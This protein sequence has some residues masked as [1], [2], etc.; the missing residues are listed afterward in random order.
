MVGAVAD[1]Q[2]P[3]WIRWDPGRVDVQ[4]SRDEGVEKAT[5]DEDECPNTVERSA[6]VVQILIMIWCNYGP[7]RGGVEFVQSCQEMYG[8]A[9]PTKN[10]LLKHACVRRTALD[11][12]RFL[13][14]AFST[15]FVLQDSGL[16]F[17]SG[18]PAFYYLT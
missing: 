2:M 16:G 4:A 15:N 14:Q 7:L 1:L 10:V 6:I 18:P 13:L 9:P 3:E 8:L 11:V 17:F 5:L 12:E